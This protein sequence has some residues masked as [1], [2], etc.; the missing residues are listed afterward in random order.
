MPAM[1]GLTQFADGVLV[2]A[3]DLNNI[4]NNINT[5]ATLAAGKNTA[6]GASAKPLVMVK[7]TTNRSVTSATTTVIPWDTTVANTDSMWASAAASMITVQ[8]GGWYD[9][10]L[11]VAWA[12][13][14]AGM[15]SSMIFV[16]GTAYP[17]NL[18]AQQ[19]RTMAASGAMYVQA[20]LLER[21]APGATIAGGYYQSSGAALSTDSVTNGGVWM[22]AAWKAPY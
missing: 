13:G 2:H 15:H 19:D 7:Q 5:L 20:H 12:S 6:S 22:S 14:A 10:T 21:L 4:G 17:T 16:N 18:A 8:T 9:I 3:A 11:Q 1:T